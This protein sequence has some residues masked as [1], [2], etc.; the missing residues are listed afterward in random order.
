[1]R[2]IRKKLL[3]SIIEKL[4][5]KFEDIYN[6]DRHSYMIIAIIKFYCFLRKL[7]NL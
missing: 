5:D 3:I 4:Y 7:V 2:F 1:M 6:C